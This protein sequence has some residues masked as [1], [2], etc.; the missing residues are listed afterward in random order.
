M[1]QINEMKINTKLK[2]RFFT[3]ISHKET[4]FIV[5]MKNQNEVVF[6]EIKMKKFCLFGRSNRMSICNWTTK[7]AVVQQQK[8]KIYH[9]RT[10]R[11]VDRGLLTFF[12][13]IVIQVQV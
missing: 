8:K 2:K 11:L 7:L 9:W 3:N 4:L 13:R 5:V 10:G 1:K 12:L 6:I